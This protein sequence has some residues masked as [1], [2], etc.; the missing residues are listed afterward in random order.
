MVKAELLPRKLS[1][2]FL[3]FYYVIPFNVG[4]GPTTGSGIGSGMYSHIQVPLQQKVSVPAI[5]VPLRQKVP[6]AAVPVLHH[7]FDKV[8]KRGIL[9][10]GHSAGVGGAGEVAQGQ[11]LLQDLQPL[12]RL[13]LPVPE[14]K[15]T[16]L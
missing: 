5:T 9:P 2:L 11:R 15:V 13:L 1:S 14:T 10:S 12:S 16:L 6:V 3:I 7:C 4:S 8:Y